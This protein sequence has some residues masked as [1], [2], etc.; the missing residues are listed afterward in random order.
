MTITGGEYDEG[1]M[2]VYYNDYSLVG[3]ALTP[4]CHENTHWTGCAVGLAEVI[5]LMPD[6]SR[7]SKIIGPLDRPVEV[8]P[9]AMHSIK[10]LELPCRTTCRYFHR[11]FL[12]VVVERF[13]GN[14]VA[15]R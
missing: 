4:H 13:N 11:N 9:E 2:Y 12:G 1:P 15:H 10:A 6:G 5:L 3:D 14:R 7:R 8:P